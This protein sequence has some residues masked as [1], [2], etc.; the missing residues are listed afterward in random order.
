MNGKCQGYICSDKTIP[1]FSTTYLHKIKQ[2]L[3]LFYVLKWTKMQRFEITP[4]YSSE[5]INDIIFKYFL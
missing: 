1:T 2:P 4:N 5:V 3:F